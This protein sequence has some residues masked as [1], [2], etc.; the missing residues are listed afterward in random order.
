MKEC[1]VVQR[2]PPLTS[3]AQGHPLILTT[4]KKPLSRKRK[5]FC[6]QFFTFFFFFL[7]RWNQKSKG[8]CPRKTRSVWLVPSQI[9]FIHI[10]NCTLMTETS[11]SAW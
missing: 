8:C 7:S 9:H 4:T 5:I 3:G 11:H 6:A 1:Y 10:K 2:Q